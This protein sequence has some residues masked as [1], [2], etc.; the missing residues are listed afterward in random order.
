[1][2]L[3]LNFVF[4]RNLIF[5]IIGGVNRRY[6]FLS[7][8]F[9]A[10]PA[11]EEY[12]LAY[13]YA[14][15]RHLMR[16]SPWPVGIYR[17]DGKWGLMFVISSTERDFYPS[18]N[19]QHLRHLVERTEHIRQ[20]TGA[21]QKTFAGV[22]PGVLFA[23]RIIRE[24]VEA[25]VTVEAV[26]R[27]EQLARETVGYDE[28]SP[29]ILLGG[30]GFIGRRLQARLKNRASYCVDTADEDGGEWPSDLKGE[31]AIVINISRKGSLMEY[32]EDWWPELVL[33]NEVYPEPSSAVVSRLTEIGSRAYHVVGVRALSIPPFPK[34]Y[35]GG[36]PCCAAR[37][38][39]EMR[40]II[41]PMNRVSGL[42]GPTR[43]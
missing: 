31:K 41:K 36:I 28:D 24:A 4:N 19:A 16:W 40:V 27:A 1:M 15:H 5:K 26:V 10:Y 2:I 8:I 14:S 7:S 23:K 38:S 42:L 9:V 3:I 22:L 6:N 18:E 20:L 17:Q 30:K 29:V 33:L 32:L 11:S 21:M 37:M 34:A 12:A 43:S 25:D 13:V 39:D 35:A